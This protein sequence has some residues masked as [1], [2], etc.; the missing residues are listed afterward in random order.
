MVQDTLDLDE[1]ENHNFVVKPEYD[2]YLE[3]LAEKL[4]SVRD[5][6]DAEHRRAAG[7]L[8]LDL[9]KKLH[10][11]NSPNWGYCF[12]MSKN[13]SKKIEKDRA[14]T[15]LGQLKN[16]VFFTTRA[17]KD[18]AEEYSETVAK[19][20]AKQSKLVGEIVAIAATYTPIL[21]E[22]NGVIAHLDVII[23]CVV[24]E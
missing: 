2:A 3:E 19:Y 20:K 1:L 9:D 24:N 5:E 6:L 18:L 16:G 4:K 13:D 17:L 12:R 7:D 15:E 23:R 10:L 14:Y 8:S 11:E 22:W 21:E